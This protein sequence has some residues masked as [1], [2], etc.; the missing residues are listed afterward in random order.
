MT[1]TKE[2]WLLAPLPNA[3]RRIIKKPVTHVLNTKNFY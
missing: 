1:T 3:V 2:F